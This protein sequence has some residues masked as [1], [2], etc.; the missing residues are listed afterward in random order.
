MLLDSADLIKENVDSLLNVTLPP[1]E[2]SLATSEFI[3]E[4]DLNWN[5]YLLFVHVE[6]EKGQLEEYW[7]VR[8]EGSSGGMY[9]VFAYPGHF[10]RVYYRNRIVTYLIE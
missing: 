7:V 1:V 10:M 5:P 4:E 9:D 3:E 6:N 8:L 2:D